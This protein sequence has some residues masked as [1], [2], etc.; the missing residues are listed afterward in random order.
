MKI[1]ILGKSSKKKYVISRHVNVQILIMAKY[2]QPVFTSLVSI[3]IFHD[4][5]IIRDM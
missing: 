3:K 1:I 2:K 4:N 5:H